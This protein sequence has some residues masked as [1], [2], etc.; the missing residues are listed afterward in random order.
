[1]AW[2]P[3]A[4]PAK[5]RG[6]MTLMTAIAPA[7]PTIISAAPGFE[8]VSPADIGW[9]VI[10]QSCAG[11]GASRLADIRASHTA[12]APLYTMFRRLSP[13]DARAELR[14]K[15]HN[16]TMATGEA[17][18]EGHDCIPLQPGPPMTQ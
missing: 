13:P 14:M 11:R 9:A 6:G 12:A 17:A 18:M 1:M 8:L 5:G 16:W 15:R 4:S 3:R 10:T 2:C 7:S